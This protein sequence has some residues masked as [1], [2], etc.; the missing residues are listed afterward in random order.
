M[1]LTR[2]VYGHCSSQDIHAVTLKILSSIWQIESGAQVLQIF[3][4]WA[5]HMSEEQFVEF[6]KVE[7][8][9]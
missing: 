8:I 7:T 3:E 5:H 1:R 4:S 2:Y 6:A 9:L